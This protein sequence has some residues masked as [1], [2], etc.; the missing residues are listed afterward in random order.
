[1]FCEA[2]AQQWG[3]LQ[4]SMTV[5]TEFCCRG[6]WSRTTAFRTGNSLGM[7]ATSTIFPGLPHRHRRVW[8]V[9]MAGLWPRRMPALK[10]VPDAGTA[11]VMDYSLGVS[12]F[13]VSAVLNC[14]ERAGFGQ[15]AL[16]LH[17][18]PIPASGLHELPVRAGFQDAA[19]VQDH[20]PVGSVERGQAV[21]DGNH[22]AIFGKGGQRRMDAS[23]RLEIQGGGRLV[24][25]QD[26][27]IVQN[28]PRDGDPLAFTTGQAL[29]ALADK[30]VV[31]I[32]AGRDEVMG[33]SNVGRR[34]DVGSGRL[35]QGVAACSRLCYRTIVRG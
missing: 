3:W 12:R 15:D 22:G 24:E 10:F 20:Q 8:K 32:R 31:S 34:H 2:I 19:A 6:A 27:R 29:P 25:D 4:G 35:E 1:M 13:L 30:R 11:S 33:L 26:A 9:W 16:C 17:H 5:G 18:G 28:R 14:A 21:G 23:L 7:V